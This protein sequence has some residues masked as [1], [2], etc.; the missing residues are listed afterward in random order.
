[1]A[2]SLPV[3]VVIAAYEVPVVGLQVEE[4]TVTIFGAL[5]VVVLIALSGFFS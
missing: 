4:S 1:M 2:F 5:A 3:E